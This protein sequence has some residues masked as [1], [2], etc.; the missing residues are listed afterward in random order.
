MKCFPWYEFEGLLAWDW[1]S[2]EL[3]DDDFEA[4]WD[5]I[6]VMKRKAWQIYK[7]CHLNNKFTGHKVGRVDGLI[8]WSC[9]AQD[10]VTLSTDGSVK[11]VN[12][13]AAAGG[14][15]RQPSWGLDGWI[16][17]SHGH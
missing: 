12:S 11:R 9:P 10:W 2:H 5:S 8:G 17:G 1:R 7:A 16:Y 4:P 6:M 14:L 3:L 15:V 13:F